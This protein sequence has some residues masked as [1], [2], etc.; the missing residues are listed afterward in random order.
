MPLS[1]KSLFGPRTSRVSLKPSGVSFDAKSNMSILEAALAQGIAFPHSCTVGTCGSCKCK[2]KEGKIRELTDFAYI[3]SGEELRGGIVLACQAA[4]RG[5]VVL[6]IEG[7]ENRHLHPA[8]DFKGR[9]V[10]TK[11]LTHDVKSVRVQLDKAIE[12]DAGQYAAIDVPGIFGKRAY[13]FANTPKS[14]GA[15]EI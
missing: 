2:L 11:N 14:N 1:F 6:E 9:I 7:V 4:P 15:P 13:S 3:L 8:G 12:F 10:E 5:D